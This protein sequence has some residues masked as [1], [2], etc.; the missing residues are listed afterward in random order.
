MPDIPLTKIALTGAQYS[1][2]LWRLDTAAQWNK[3]PLTAKAYGLLAGQ[4]PAKPASFT[5]TI[6]EWADLWGRGPDYAKAMTRN[7]TDQGRD[8]QAGDYAQA[9]TRYVVFLGD[10][11]NGDR[12]KFDATDYTGT[13]QQMTWKSSVRG[14]TV[15]SGVLKLP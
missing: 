12:I 15:Q 2:L 3:E 6:K 7:L 10:A 8:I 4:V 5:G 9:G 13:E 14:I 11:D 1:V